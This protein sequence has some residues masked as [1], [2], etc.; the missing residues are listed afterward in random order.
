MAGYLQT[1]KNVLASFQG[2]KEYT[3]SAKTQFRYSVESSGV[4]LD[5]YGEMVSRTLVSPPSGA[6]KI[7]YGQGVALANL[8]VKHA[9]VE[10][11]GCL[12]LAIQCK[13]GSSCIRS[14]G[15]QRGSSTD[16]RA[17]AWLTIEINTRE[18]GVKILDALT[19]VAPFYPAGDGETHEIP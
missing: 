13:N 6:A 17:L 15:V 7:N 2:C 19:A 1:I 10:N 11:H 16:D 5:D 18:Q 4:D 12:L 8:D 14:E 3:D 9:I